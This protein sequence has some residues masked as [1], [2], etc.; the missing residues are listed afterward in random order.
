MRTPDHLLLTAIRPVPSP[1][2]GRSNSELGASLGPAL[3]KALT[4][5]MHPL[6]QQAAVGLMH[7]N[8][9]PVIEEKLI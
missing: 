4:P 7:P 6:G 1:G 5:L 3:S 8:I 9:N 2:F